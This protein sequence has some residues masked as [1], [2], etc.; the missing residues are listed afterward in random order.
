MTILAT[1]ESLSHKRRID[2]DGDLMRSAREL[3]CGVTGLEL[4][5]LFE[6][7]KLIGSALELDQALHQVLYILNKR[8]K[9]ERATLM[10]LDESGTHLNIRAS[11]GLTPEQERRG[12]YRISEG[13]CG[14]VFRSS[15]P[16]V[17]RDV[18]S[19]PLFLN[20][21]KARKN[22][23]KGTISF[24]GVPIVLNNQAVGVLTV[25]R[26]FGPDISFEED[27]RFLSV[28]ATL[29]GQFLV[30]H[31]AIRLHHARLIEENLDLKAELKGKYSFSNVVGNSKALREVFTIIER[32]APSSATV[33]ILGESGTGKG[34]IARAIHQASARSEGPFIKVNCAALPENLLESE[35]FGHERGA[36][37]GA[38]RQRPGR[39]EL[40]H[41]GTLFLDEIGELPLSLQSKLLRVIQEREFER[42]GSSRTIT[43][44]VRLIAATNRDLEK[45]VAANEFRA[46]LYYRLNVVPIQVPPL[47]ERR[48]DIP[49]LVD[50]FLRESNRRHG[51]EVF[52]SKE[53]LETLVR[54][55]WPGNVRELENLVERLVIMADTSEIGI[56]D[57]PLYIQLDSGAGGEGSGQERAGAVE[58]R[59]R[60]TLREMEKR[61]IEAALARNG[62]V[63]ARAAKELG[64]TQRQIG[65]KIKKYG[66]TPPW[67][68]RSGRGPEEGPCVRLQE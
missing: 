56:E 40:A 45:A 58:E 30:L 38:G 17:V 32:V 49:P 29:I 54:Y 42:L 53:V 46:D 67:R 13:V 41:N 23:K 19:E 55:R 4:D 5:T 31:N 63:Q 18:N 37:T 12:I 8:L 2:G 6:I 1:K 11:C 43:V 33:L 44:D 51:K 66:I 20:K 10:L 15:A 59:P 27:V 7:S 28:V 65:Y 39:F 61:E 50:K 16:F 57:L 22:I 26:L 68:K 64:L 34:L 21:T 52:M 25:D 47:R 60:L 9:M 36:F 35:L 14:K 24:I 62:W 3:H 48:E